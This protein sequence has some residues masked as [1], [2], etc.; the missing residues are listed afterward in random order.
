MEVTS[1]SSLPL[2]DIGGA[3]I[4]SVQREHPGTRGHSVGKLGRSKQVHLKTQSGGS[5]VLAVLL[6]SV[7]RACSYGL[8]WVLGY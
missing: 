1:Y 4:T 8:L 7:R 3:Q 2:L 6:S 5:N